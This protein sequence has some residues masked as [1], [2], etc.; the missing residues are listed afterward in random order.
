MFPVSSESQTE[1]NN[2]GRMSSN[3]MLL[4]II[5]KSVTSEYPYLVS[6]YD[7]FMA[8]RG[9][10]GGRLVSVSDVRTLAAF[11]KSQSPHIFST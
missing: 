1:V 8:K 9:G 11:V 4:K 10:G 2:F 6:T 5:K 7:G 3:G